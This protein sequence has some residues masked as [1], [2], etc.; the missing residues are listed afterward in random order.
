MRMELK[1]KHDGST[2]RVLSKGVD[3]DGKTFCHLASTTMGRW[4]RNGFYPTQINDWVP[5]EVLAIAE[6]Y[7]D[8][9]NSGLAALTAHRP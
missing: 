4:Q 9:A 2:W 1:I 3:R 7:T 8:R 6:H 5:N